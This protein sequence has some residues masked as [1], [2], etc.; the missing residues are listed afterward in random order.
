MGKDGDIVTYPIENGKVL[1]VVA[2]RKYNESTWA[3]DKWVVDS[4]EEELLQDFEGWGKCAIKIL[5]VSS[6]TSRRASDL[7]ET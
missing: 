7:Q 1:N 3:H 6:L 4:T 2:F 5:K